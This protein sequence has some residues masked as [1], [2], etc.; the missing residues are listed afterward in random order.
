MSVPK[1]TQTL[2]ILWKHWDPHKNFK[3]GSVFEQ[4]P[5]VL[6]EFVTADLLAACLNGQIKKSKLE[7]HQIKNHHKDLGIIYIGYVRMQQ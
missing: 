1:D 3:S 2:Q 4:P 6:Q 5:A 7:R